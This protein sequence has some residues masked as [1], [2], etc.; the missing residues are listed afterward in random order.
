MD[1]RNAIKSLLGRLSGA[2]LI[3]LYIAAVL[4]GLKLFD[5]FAVGSNLGTDQQTLPGHYLDAAQRTAGTLELFPYEG[6]HM[7]ANARAGEF[8]LG[9]MGFAIDFDVLSPPEKQADEYRIILIGGS[10]AQGWGAS[11]T[12][13][14]MARLLE[15]LLNERHDGRTYRV[16]N[17][18]MGAS[19]T[20]QNFI[21][22]NRWAHPLKPDLILSYSGVNDY[23]VP[24]VHTG[25]RDAHYYFNE[26]NGL[27]M[28]ARASEMPPHLSWL[29]WF[30]PNL[31]TKTTI[32]YGIKYALF[33][34]YFLQRAQQSYD[35]SYGKRYTDPN[36]FIDELVTP[37]YIHAMQSI[38]RD[39][40][41]VP[42]LIVWQAWHES[43]F[44]FQLSYMPKLREDFYDRMY[45]QV[46]SRLSGPGWHV[47]NFQAQNRKM[48]SPGIFVHPN[49]KGQKL[50]AQYV[51]QKL[52][53]VFAGTSPACL[54][55]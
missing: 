8:R 12:E 4:I 28:A 48:P 55:D 52:D 41:G 5:L 30:L 33:P 26:L 19:V 17:L 34:S 53:C 20:Y 49:D 42:I 54:V 38:R 47:A 7:Q 10:G 35:R 21:A 44:K 1:W 36:R 25:M 18:A 37:N 31:M 2:T 32:G 3:V 40:D 50:L 13:T 29:V 39:F 14:T 22:L 11:S 15:G 6:W 51:L 27:A 24:L 23:F 45:Q 9:S 46:A 43:E 16:I